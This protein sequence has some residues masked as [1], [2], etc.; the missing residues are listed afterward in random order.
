MPRDGIVTEYLKKLVEKQVNDNGTVVWYDPDKCYQEVSGLLE[1]PRTNIVR[2]GGSFIELRRQIDEMGLLD[3]QEPSRLVVYV[4]MNQADCFHALVELEA[5]GIVM[6]PGQQPAQ[7]NTRLAVVARNALK[8]VLADD[9][10]TALEKQVEAG[11]LTLQDLDDL[12]VKG[13]EISQSFLPLIFETSNLSEITLLFLNSD[14]F[15][16]KIHVKDA[17]EELRRVIGEISG[18]EVAHGMGLQEMRLSL[19]RHI[20]MTEFICGMGSKIPPKLMA[21]PIASSEET[22]RTCSEL[23]KTWRKRTDFRDSYVSSSKRIQEELR[24]DSADFDM[25][26]ICGIETFAAV[27]DALLEHVENELL[28][29]VTDNLTELI[30][31]RREGFW[32]DAEA[33]FGTRWTLINT[34]ADV[35][36]EAN[37]LEGELKDAPADVEAMINAYASGDHPW[38]V[39]DTYHRKME[40]LWS[41]FEPHN[42]FNDGIEKLVI[43]SRQRYSDVSSKLSML[44]LTQIKKKS[45]GR[46]VLSQR[47]IYEKHVAPSIH[48]EKTAY[49]WV[50]ALR[51]EMG[52][53]LLGSIGNEFDVDLYPVMA[54]APTITEIG[55]AS[56]LPHADVSPKIAAVSPGKLGL[57]LKGTLIKDR[58]DR[59]DYLKANAGAKVFVAKLDDLLPKPKKKDRDGIAT[60]ELILVTSQEIDELGEKDAVNRSRKQMS[61]ILR[62][63]RR[64]IKG[65]IELG[66][67]RIVLTADHGHIFGEELGD[68]MKIDPPGGNTIDLHRRVWIGQGGNADDAFVRFPLSYFGIGGDMDIATPWTFA[69]FKCKGAAKAYFHGGLSLQEIVVPLLIIRP[70]S[71]ASFG[72]TNKF[73]WK[74]TPGS[75]KLTTRF[76]SIQ[77]S[78]YCDGLFDFE[79]PRVRVEI[80]SK[81]KTISRAVSAAY[82]FDESTRE[83]VLRNSEDDPRS[84]KPNTV[85]LMIVDDPDQNTVDLKLYEAATGLELS[86]IDNI[87]VAISI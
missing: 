71:R 33:S 13:G 75:N 72:K 45:S 82:G 74:M 44:F 22:T 85:A 53:D 84:I 59:I 56:L 3:G 50:D 5:A 16:E 41:D 66:V 21:I 57:E 6:Q 68:E 58:N 83:V 63:L 28:N 86:K 47:R 34:A 51:F 48:K 46:E 11:K 64:G 80:L 67:E 4:P 42:Y 31:V 26:S 73:T 1:L 52:R 40:S 25:E 10:I 78:G 15:D 87:E 43:K 24:L 17:L 27:E 62:D 81:K 38:C 60:S 77:I 23:A 36:V 54:S 76:F 69:C 9:T 65:L 70:S 30:R 19:S 55:M 7:R 12:A 61:E 2:Y 39:L 49:I 37:R 20:L 29:G 35:M 32:H 18:L 14:T 79:P 8:G